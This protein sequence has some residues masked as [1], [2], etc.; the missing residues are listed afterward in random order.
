MNVVIKVLQEGMQKR[1]QSQNEVSDL[2]EI[3]RRCVTILSNL[4][5]SEGNDTRRDI[6]NTRVLDVLAKTLS[7]PRD[8]IDLNTIDCTVWFMHNLTKNFE[9]RHVS[10]EA[11]EPLI[12]SL[13]GLLH[14]PSQD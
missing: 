1:L 12:Y 7:A 3:Y 14:L 6:L 5:Q 13:L 2:F 8:L 9:S 4:S 11:E 10:E